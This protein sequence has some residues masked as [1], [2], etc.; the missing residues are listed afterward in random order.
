MSARIL[1]ISANRCASPYPVYPLGVGVLARRL[2]E[3][4]NGTAVFDALVAERKGERLDEAIASF[5]PDLIAVSIRNADNTDSVAPEFFLDDARKT[6]DEVRRACNAPIIAGGPAI[7]LLGEAALA[8]VGADIGV[9]GEGEAAMVEIVDA[10]E[11]DALPDQR[12]VRAPSPLAVDNIGGADYEPDLAAF[13]LNEGGMLPVQTKRGCPH[14]CD[15]CVYPALE[16]GRFRHRAP[17]TVVDDIERLIADSNA[18]YL[19]F[20]DSVFND[21]KGRYL[22]VAEEMIRREIDVRW[23]AFLRP[24]GMGRG[25]FRLLRRAGL[26]AAEFGSDAASN[27]TLAGLGKALTMNEVTQSTMDANAEGIACAHFMLFGGPNETET[28][29]EEGLA[30]VAA[31]TDCVVFAGVGARVYPNTSLR[32]RAVADGLITDDADLT[33]PTFYISPHIDGAAVANRLRKE[34]A[35]RR[36]RVFDDPDGLKRAAALRMFG[37]RGPLWDFLLAKR[38]RRSRN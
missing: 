4:G 19:F 23:T 6:V 35:D 3:R 34:F 37:H 12:L 9:I 36:D 17:E 5:R 11:R 30:N 21:S 29:L 25:E 28:T 38:G 8:H 10:F 16:G 2:R 32:R 18:D 7:S 27:A 33:R 15:Y 13:Y 14:C 26:H 31:L 20:A 1:L 24:S 22:E